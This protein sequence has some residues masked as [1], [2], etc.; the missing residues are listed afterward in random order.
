MRKIAFVNEKGGSCKTTLTVSVGAYLALY[1]GA[2]VLLC[3][4]DPQGQVAKSLGIDPRGLPLSMTDLLNDPT[5]K[6]RDVVHH[7]RIEGLDV[8]PSNKTLTDFSIEAAKRQ[9]RNMRLKVQID[10]VRGYDYV[11]FDSPPSLGLLTMNIMMATRE[12]VIPVNLT[13]LALDGCAEIVDTMEAVRSNYNRRE[14]RVSLVVP[15]LYRPTRLAN[16]ILEKL[17]EYFGDRL[18]PNVI[19]FNVAIDEAQSQGL[20]IWE[21]SRSSRG[22]QMLAALAEEIAAIKAD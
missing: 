18:S 5:V 4:L 11:L 22:A 19:G 17:G 10:R 15:T 6:L 20:T 16:A 7:S 21:Y 2:R 14:L 9:D 12:I 8:V 13:F 3:D 1:K